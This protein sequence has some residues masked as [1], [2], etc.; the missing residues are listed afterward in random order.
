MN[1]EEA[2]NSADKDF[3]PLLTQIAQNAP[4]V[5]YSPDFNPACALIAKQKADDERPREHHPHRVRRLLGRDATP[6][7]AAPPPTACSCP[8]RT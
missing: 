3:K 8:A 7:S 6:R 4:D 2:I 1:A 5:I